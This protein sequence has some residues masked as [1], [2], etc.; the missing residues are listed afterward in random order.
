VFSC[1]GSGRVGFNERVVHGKQFTKH[2][3]EFI[4]AETN[5]FHK[6]FKR[7]LDAANMR[8]MLAHGC[9]KQAPSASILCVRTNL[10]YLSDVEM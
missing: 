8:T 5:Q 7:D 6:Q 9:G 3:I 4:L 2:F 10:F 1:N